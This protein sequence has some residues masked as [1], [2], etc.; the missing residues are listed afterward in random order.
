MEN[1]FTTENVTFGLGILAILFSV[2]NYFRNPQM[3]AEKID[4]LLEQRVKFMNE[5]NERRFCDMN[6]SIKDAY[7]L[8]N[9]HIHT[10]DTKVENLIKTIGIMSNEI[11][12]L[13]TII[14]E[15]IPK[16]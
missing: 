4:A 7:G 5:S 14:E 1:L 3:K 16:K 6:T 2:Y 15:R 13:S 10:V 11:T 9:N 8:A 12:R